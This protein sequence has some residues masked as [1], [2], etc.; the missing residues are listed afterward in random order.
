M[1]N[2]RF[3]PI[4]KGHVKLRGFHIGG[5][6]PVRL[7]AREPVVGGD[8]GSNKVVGIITP[9]SPKPTVD[10]GKLLKHL[11]FG[12]APKKDNERIKFLF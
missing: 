7:H 1:S 10:G 8:V 12:D 2:H 3:I 9:E 6:V 11:H 5:A 4:H